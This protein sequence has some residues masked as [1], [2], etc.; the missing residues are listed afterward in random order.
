M[1]ASRDSSRRERFWFAAIL[2]LALAVRVWDLNARSL[3]FD[4]AGEYWVSTAPFAHLAESVRTGTGDP[5]LY[6][7][8]LHTWMQYGTSE[9]WLRFLTVIASVGGVAGVIVLTRLMVGGTVAPAVAGVLLALLPADVRYAQEVGQYGFVPAIVAW[10]LVFLVM[11]TRELRWRAVLGWALTALGA[12]Y[13]YYGT[14]FPIASAFVCVVVESIFR[15]DARTRRATGTGLVLYILGMLPLVIWYLPTQLARV[16]G[17]DSVSS[18]ARHTVTGILQKK[19]QMSC[20]LLAFQFTGWPH[21]HIAPALVIAPALFLMVV[22][23]RRAPRLLIWFAVAINVY[24]AADA[25]GI[26]PLGYRWGLIMTPLIICAIAT[27]VV[28]PRRKWLQWAAIAAFA[29]LIA[30]DVYS[31][32]NRTLRD[33]V[34]KDP[35]GAWPE[36]EDMRGIAQFWK[37]QRT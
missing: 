18:S 33:R 22:A 35:S 37:E 27:A 24:A 9:A 19:W 16:V 5:P 15:R 30:V 34:Y 21:T 12:S 7:F 20:E 8:L 4:E 6:E 13:L 25:L 26:F 28:A 14:I 11:M 36:T 10:N 31:L 17:G 1:I 29:L 2:V 3:W 32:P 23:I